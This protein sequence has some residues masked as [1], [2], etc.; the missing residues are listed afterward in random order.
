MEYIYTWIEYI[1]TGDIGLMKYIYMEIIYINWRY[2][3]HGIDIH[4]D[5]TYKLEI[6]DSWNIYTW[7]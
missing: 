1:Q 7:R 4:G 3:T 6:L 5:N 2:W